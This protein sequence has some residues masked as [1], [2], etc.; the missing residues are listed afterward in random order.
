MCIRDSLRYIKEN[1]AML[2][3]AM[4]SNEKC[5][6]IVGIA[7][8]HY[9][10][11]YFQQ[12]IKSGKPI[13]YF[14]SWPY[15]NFNSP[16]SRWVHHYPID[17]RERWKSFLENVDAIVCVTKAS[18]NA[19]QSFS[20]KV[21]WIPHSVDTK[22]FRPKREGKNR[23]SIVVLFVGRLVES[24]GIL[25]LMDVAKKT[26]R[27][28]LKN[29]QFWFVGRGPFKHILEKFE[30]VLPIRYLGYVD[31]PVVLAKIYREADILVLPSKRKRTWEE[32]FG[33]VIIEGMSS[34]LPVIA[35]NHIGPREVIEDQFDGFI[36]KTD[37]SLDRENFV[38]EILDRILLLANDENLRRKMGIRGRSKAKQWY[39][40]RINSEKWKRVLEYIS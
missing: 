19:L 26:K 15:W 35:S 36:I 30:G 4:L 10:V 1:I 20:K 9:F 38:N 32:L 28:G 34:G 8:L 33:I 3:K 7:P 6:N 37:P 11:Y 17:L 12:F 22:I 39:D 13:I 27:I 14:T 24:K 29:L 40:V 21:F 2:Y 16:Y 23:N 31:D 25:E 18:H 5:I